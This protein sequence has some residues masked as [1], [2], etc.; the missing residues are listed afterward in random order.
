[1]FSEE[2]LPILCFEFLYPA[3]PGVHNYQVAGGGWGTKLFVSESV[4][5]I[6][7]LVF[8]GDWDTKSCEL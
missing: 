3:L 2:I 1:M 5:G 4:W 7:M 8:I 6:R